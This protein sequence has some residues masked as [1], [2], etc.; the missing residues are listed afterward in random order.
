MSKN[1]NVEIH[2]PNS[3]TYVGHDFRIQ[4]T[5]FCKSYQSQSLLFIHNSLHKQCEKSWLLFKP[6]ISNVRNVN[7]EEKHEY[8][9]SS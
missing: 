1:L 6:S 8:S 5:F 4:Q 7:Q 3:C 2:I 9:K